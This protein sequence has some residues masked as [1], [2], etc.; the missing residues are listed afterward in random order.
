VPV[1]VDTSALVA[2]VRTSESYHAAVVAAIALEEGSI[3]IPLTVVVEA[4]QMISSRLGPAAESA[5]VRGLASGP[6]AI[7]PSGAPDLERAAALIDRYRDVDIG[8]VDATIV[9]MAERLGAIRIYTLDR[10][11][12]GIIR[13]RHVAAFDLL[14]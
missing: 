6:W 11:D 10:R 12:F 7:E 13:P 14:P 3:V 4:S 5:W 9:A 2:L 8:F 1:I